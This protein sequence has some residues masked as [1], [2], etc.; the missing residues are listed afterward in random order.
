MTVILENYTI[1]SLG[2]FEI[3]RPVNLTLSAREAQRR[4]NSWLCLDVSMM[5]TGGEPTLIVV[6]V[7]R[8]QVPVIYTAPHVGHV[9]VVGRV[10]VDA[11]TGTIDKDPAN[12]EAIFCA[13]KKLSKTLPPFTPKE[14]P[15][16]YLAKFGHL[17]PTP[18]SQLKIQ[19]DGEVVSDI[20]QNMD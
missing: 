13:A 14:L 11:Q 3:R 6:E 4:V 10:E 9:G 12:L 8:W 18:A 16:E 1:S 20:T 15:P 5:L 17:L 2:P 7:T 19:A